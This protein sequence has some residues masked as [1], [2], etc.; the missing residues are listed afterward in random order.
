MRVRL[1]ER[2]HDKEFESIRLP[3][4]STHQYLPIVH[5]HRFGVQPLELRLSNEAFKLTVELWV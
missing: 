4:P 2:G 1:H 3:A 5:F